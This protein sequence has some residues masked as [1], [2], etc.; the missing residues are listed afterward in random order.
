LQANSDDVTFDD[1]LVFVESVCQLRE[2]RDVKL[3]FRGEELDL[4]SDEQI[5]ALADNLLKL[6]ELYVSGYGVTDATLEKVSNLRHLRAMTFFSITSF[7]V[8]GLLEFVSRLGPGNQGLSL[9][10]DMADPASAISEAEQ[11]LVR[12]ALYEKVGGRFEYQLLRGMCTWPST[13]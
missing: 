5:Q 8:D 7:T 13:R 12:E 11:D 9:V 2:L 1:K 3:V 6:E 10:V 4:L